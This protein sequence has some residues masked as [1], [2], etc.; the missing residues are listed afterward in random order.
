MRHRSIDFSFMLARPLNDPPAFSIDALDRLVA[1][2]GA[3]V[4]SLA[5]THEVGRSSLIGRS[6]WEF[7][8]SGLARSLWQVLHHRVRT[9][10]A[11][12]FFP[13]RTDSMCERML[14]DVELHALGNDDIRHVHRPMWRESRPAIALLDPSHPRDDRAHRRCVWC[15]RLQVEMGLWLEVEAAQDALGLASSETLPIV[16][17]G[18][19]SA[20]KQAVL[21]NFPARA[22]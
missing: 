6:L 1:V 4:E 12:L 18:V 20:C 8:P 2:N 10:G 3:F 19:C 16:K 13:V 9:I 21:K 15:A 5:P 11:P 7:M 17:D 14:I 22:A